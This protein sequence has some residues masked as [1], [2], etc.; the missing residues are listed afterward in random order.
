MA[1]RIRRRPAVGCHLIL[2]Y[3]C[4]LL[5]CATPAAAL[6]DD[7]LLLT[8]DFATEAS[9]GRGYLPLV[10][11][12]PVVA[13]LFQSSFVDRPHLPPGDEVRQTIGLSATAWGMTGGHTDRQ[14]IDN[15]WYFEFTVQATRHHR[16]T[17]SRLLFD[18]LVATTDRAAT[19]WFLTSSIDGFTTGRI[20]AAGRVTATPTM[21]THLWQTF[22][23]DLSGN[24]A[25]Q[26]LAQAV[27][28]R[29]Y[30]VMDTV[31]APNPSGMDWTQINSVAVMGSAV[32]TRLLP[33]IH[34]HVADYGALGDGI[35]DDG[36]AVRAAFAAAAAAPNPARLVFAADAVY[37]LGKFDAEFNQVQIRHT[38]DL[39]VEGNGAMWVIDPLNRGLLIWHSRD[40]VVRD[41]N[42]DFDPLPFT[43]GTVLAVDPTAGTFEFQIADAYPDVDPPA[44][45]VR[46]SDWDNA[47]F[48][49]AATGRFTHNWVYPS[50]LVP[51]PNVAKRYT[52]HVVAEQW[53]KLQTVTSGQVFVMN[54]HA[55]LLDGINR[56]RNDALGHFYSI[57]SFTNVIRH[58][59][60]VTLERVNLHAFGGRAYSILDSVAV[61]L[62]ACTVRRKPG[63]DRAVSG[64]RG[65]LIMKEL[66]A[67][68]LIRDSYFDGTMDDSL[69][70]SDTPC[71]VIAR[72]NN[73]LTLR[74][75]GNKWSDA[76]HRAGDTIEFWDRTGLRSLGQATIVETIRD[77]HRNHRILVDQ[78]P[79]GV[80]TADQQSL[81]SA[82]L[83]YLMVE[84]PLQVSGSAF[85]TQLKKAAIVRTPAIFDNCTFEES[86]YGIHAYST[87]DDLEGPYPRNQLFRN[88]QFNNV[89]IGAIVVFK[90][91]QADN[92]PNQ[93]IV[94]EG[95]RIYQ[96]GTAIDGA[97]G[98]NITNINGV[99]IR[100][101]VIRFAADVAPVHQLLRV[102]GTPTLEQQQLYLV[103]ERQP[104]VDTDMDGLPDWWEVA[105]FGDLRYGPGDD[106][107]GDG[108]SNLDE[109]RAATNPADAR[110]RF[111]TS[112][113]AAA[114]AQLRLQWSSEFGRSYAIQRATGLDAAGWETVAH[115]IPAR[116]PTN[117]VDYPLP[118]QSQGAQFTRIVTK[119]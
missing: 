80:V 109:Y 22:T 94:I 55:D 60:Y 33:A 112:V 107:D 59:Q 114:G 23:V 87:A 24:R 7:G 34:Y 9:A 105:Y 104:P 2:W 12:V 75:G 25:F 96:D 91:G 50:R 63:T 46:R 37:R 49:E 39:T 3:G 70:R 115:D 74:F 66:R 82:T 116:P 86:N 6:A 77:S 26:N 18:A 35:H 57:G 29:L 17:I 56:E 110:S 68:P 79:D 67:G 47:V 78:V 90:A 72:N 117:E 53:P 14:A 32:D 54:R 30:W 36:P 31:E 111:R 88:L 99:T 84:G 103:D 15:K 8:Y 97:N 28:F 42:I 27:T 92:V 45:E 85:G 38:Q 40:I 58:S 69:N 19:R 41:L 64:T 65:G 101:T 73:V 76:I 113:Q 51:S 13:S 16:L 52:V 98:I 93:N 44:I 4:G 5:W 100:D 118:I 81:D 71:H 20:I 95:V 48:V 119:P 61:A 89:G 11:E 106:P 1:I 102:V 83:V 21:P 43:Q 108:A 10:G 62:T